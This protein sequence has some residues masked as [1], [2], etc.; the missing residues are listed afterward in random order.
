MANVR[1]VVES[2]TA[3][4]SGL[5]VESN[6]ARV[7]VL[8]VVGSEVPA[9]YV[10]KVA[11][12]SV[13]VRVGPSGLRLDPEEILPPLLDERSVMSCVDLGVT[14]D[15]GPMEGVPVL[16]PLEH[17]VLEKSLDGGPM[18]GAPVLVPIDHSVLE[19]PL[20][21]GPMEGV[22]VLEPIEHL[23]LEKSLDGGNIEGMPVL[24][25]L[26]H[27]VLV[28][29]LD[30]GPMEGAPVLEPIE[31]SV[32][33]KPLDGGPLVEMSALEPLGHLVP[34]V[35]LVGGYCSLIRMTES[36]PLV[37][38]GLSVTVHVNMDSLWMAPWDAG[39][40]F[41]SSY[42]PGMAIS[43][44]TQS[45]VVRFSRM[46][47][48]P[49]TG[50][51]GSFGGLTRICAID[52]YAGVSTAP[53]EMLVDFNQMDFPNLQFPPVGEEV[54]PSTSVTLM[55]ADS[56]GRGCPAE[57]PFPG[58]WFHDKSGFSPGELYLGR[59]VRG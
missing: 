26:E 52:L 21:G 24:E 29:T 5:S 32:L 14:P 36:G 38:S 58:R 35:A 8:P 18:E 56:R 31:H 34:D 20:D 40:T 42:R 13:G 22:P 48:F 39:G 27:S 59:D 4:V 46:P 12:E 1:A 41:R 9:V 33:E 45:Y 50:Y 51:L 37:H 3:R 16:E 11:L 7:S 23:V 10:G 30:G 2:D 49:A 53:V 55:S 19:K 28:M 57:W 15:G 25:P 43:R 47:V 17:S 6:T 54:L 44:N